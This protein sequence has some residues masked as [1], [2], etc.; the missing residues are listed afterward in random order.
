MH[1]IYKY[2]KTLPDKGLRKKKRDG[3]IGK[4]AKWNENTEYEIEKA[5]QAR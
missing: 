4:Q 5:K 3:D 2:T 1:T